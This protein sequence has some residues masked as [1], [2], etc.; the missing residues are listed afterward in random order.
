MEPYRIYQIIVI[1]LVFNYALGRIL[2]WLNH[3]HGS[4]KLPEELADIYDA[5]KY[6]KQRAYE[7]AGYNLGF[8]S[9]FISICSVLLFFFFDAKCSR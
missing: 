2:S 3:H 8:L 5:E 6:A 4:D 7:K 1:I 9:G